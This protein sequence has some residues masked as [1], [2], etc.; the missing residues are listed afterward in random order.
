MQDAPSGSHSGPEGSDSTRTVTTKEVMEHFDV[1]AHTISGWIN[2][3]APHTRIG[4][5]KR[6]ELRFDLA[7]L[8]QWVRTAGR[9]FR[10]GRGKKG[11]GSGGDRHSLRAKLERQGINPNSEAGLGAL[12]IERQHAEAKLR[13]DLAAAEKAEMELERLRG[14]LLDAEDVK[15]GHLDRIAR[16]RAVLMGG[17]ASLAPDL[18]MQTAEVIE[19]RLRDWVFQSLHELASDTVTVEE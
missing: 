1:K 13:K 6:G 2:N 9:K 5:G 15:Q 11:P 14:Q 4:A 18:E 8:S 17:P 7:E 10:R 19:S 16:A 3:G 12:E